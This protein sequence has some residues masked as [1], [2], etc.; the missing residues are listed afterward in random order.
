[1]LSLA[2]VHRRVMGDRAEALGV[3]GEAPF[4]PQCVCGHQAGRLA[5]TGTWRR[6]LGRPGAF[7]FPPLCPYLAPASRG[8]GRRSWARGG[9]TGYAGGK[10]PPSAG[11]CARSELL[12]HSGNCFSRP[13]C[14]VDG[15]PGPR[16]ADPTPRG[17]SVPPLASTSY[18][19]QMPGGAS[20]TRDVVSMPQP[21]IGVHM[22][23]ANSA[24][25]A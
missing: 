23:R 19:E 21:P 20:L 12:L 9:G 16:A 2:G 3:C 6:F 5:C 8:G 7:S 24:L 25:G 13:L 10:P 18:I 11:S 15:I 1:M 4:L 17:W 22:L 14:P